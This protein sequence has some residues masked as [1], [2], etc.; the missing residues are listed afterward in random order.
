MMKVWYKEIWIYKGLMCGKISMIYVGKNEFNFSKV[1]FCEYFEFV[2][3]K[4]V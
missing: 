2:W 3:V 1:F 4:W